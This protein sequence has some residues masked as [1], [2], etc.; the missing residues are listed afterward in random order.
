MT[1][2]HLA[3]EYQKRDVI[4][5]ELGICV[6]KYISVLSLENIFHQKKKETR[7]HSNGTFYFW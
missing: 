4:M 1:L 7:I 2:L 5:S 6:M 3:E